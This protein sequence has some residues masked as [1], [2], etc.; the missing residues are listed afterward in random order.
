M[1]TFPIIVAGYH[2]A[3]DLSRLLPSPL[4]YKILWV[5]GGT[6]GLRY[7]P[8]AMKLRKITNE[9]RPDWVGYLFECPGCNTDHQIDNSWT[10]NGDMD[11]PTF[12]PSYR[13]WWEDKDGAHNCHCFI[14]DGFIK[15]LSD[16]THELAGTTVELPDID[17]P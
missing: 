1:S 15:F 13:C 11:K 7:A 6:C 8:G 10:F 14:T 9:H 5:V 2:G 17:I 3:D 12:N 4:L 16:C